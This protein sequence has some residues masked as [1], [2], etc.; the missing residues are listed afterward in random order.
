MET[1]QEKTAR[2]FAENINA[3]DTSKPNWPTE[4]ANLINDYNKYCWDNRPSRKH[5][6]Q[7]L[8]R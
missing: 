6:Q 4:S 1:A 7:E 2:E 5:K 3:V 8:P